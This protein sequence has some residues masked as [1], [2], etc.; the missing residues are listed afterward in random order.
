VDVV[1]D[2]AKEMT[3]QTAN[4]HSMCRLAVAVVLVALITHTWLVMGLVVPVV[5]AGSS[6]SPTLAGPHRDYRCA[7]CG[8]AFA[9]GL[10]QASPELVAVCPHCGK[11]AEG[12][13]MRDVAGERMLV[14]RTAFVLRGPRRWEVVVFRSPSG[15]GELCVKRAVGLPGETVAIVEGGLLVDGKKLAPPAG[16]KYEL[17][18]GDEG[19][20]ATGWRLGAAEYLVLGDNAEIS[21]DSRSWPTG[22]GLA[23]EL[24]VGKPLGVR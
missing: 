5:V 21:D 24:L 18:Y 6:M 10:D 2:A 22:P 12:V 4:F 23:A 13:A 17:R 19:E 9:V 3:M 11:L 20:L 15:T 14:D 7:V 16:L 1:A 8:K